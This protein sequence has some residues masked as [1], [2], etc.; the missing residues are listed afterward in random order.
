MVYTNYSYTR[1]SGNLYGEELDVA[2]GTLQTN[3]N[4]QMNFEN[5]WGAELSGWYRTRGVERTN[6]VGT[7]WANGCR[8]F[9][10][11]VKKQRNGEAERT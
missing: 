10:T 6:T 5:G 8:C 3:I 9:K 7:L 1:Y 4:N 2:A 11:G